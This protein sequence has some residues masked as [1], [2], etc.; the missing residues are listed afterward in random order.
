MV[1]RLVEMMGVMWAAY[2]AERLDVMKALLTVVLMALKLVG[3]SENC[4]VDHLV[5]RL[6]NSMV[7]C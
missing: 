6:V 1:V 4:L 2:T 3:D 5:A 7:E